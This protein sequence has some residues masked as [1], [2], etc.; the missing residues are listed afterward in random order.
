MIYYILLILTTLI[1]TGKALLC[2]AIGTEKTSKKEKM[3]LNSKVFFVAFL[4]SFIFVIDKLPQLFS[5]SLYSLVFSICF[6]I[7]L[8]VTQLM[9]MK[10]M[11]N[12]PASTVTLIFSSGFLIPIIY[13]LIFL[14]EKVSFAKWIGV[15]LLLLALVLSVA[16]KEEKKSLIA[17][18][19]AAIIS[20]VGSGIS[21]IIQKNHQSSQYSGE[22]YAFIVYCLFF[23][24]VLSFVAHLLLKEPCNKKIEIAKKQVILSKL[25]L[26]LC[27]GVCVVLSNFFNLILAGKLPSVVL[28]PIY[29]VG[30]LLLVS[31]ISFVIY[32]EKATVI[33]SV[34]FCIGVIAILIIG[35][36]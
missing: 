20:M 11:G 12:G 35:M 24:T 2:K 1:A 13:S 27:L 8:T 6:A 5:I 29:N 34:G 36:L 16:K 19:P 9:Q 30:S 31:M 4:I 22:I 28:F 17:W 23:S 25:I 7:S 14:S 10:A 15:A 18:L 21:A 3:L 32:K 26:P 33:Q